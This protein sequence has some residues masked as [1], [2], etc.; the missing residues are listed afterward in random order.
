MSVNA[1]AH[2]RVARPRMAHR[3]SEDYELWRDALPRKLQKM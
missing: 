3:Y 2:V 1:D